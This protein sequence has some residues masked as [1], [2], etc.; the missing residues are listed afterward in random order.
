MTPERIAELRALHKS[1]TNPNQTNAAYL[2]AVQDYVHAAREVLPK[3]LDE[4]E[5]L[6]ELVDDAEGFEQSARFQWN[7]CREENTRLR[8]SL[9]KIALCEYDHGNAAQGY[10]DCWDI[11]RRA[12]QPEGES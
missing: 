5:R 9:Q 12:L 2:K 1:A 3:L 10:C 8:A 6:R 4:V 7:L 11:A